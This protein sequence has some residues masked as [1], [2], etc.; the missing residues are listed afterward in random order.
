MDF[1]FTPTEEQ[2][3]DELREWLEMNLPNGWMEGQ[4]VLPD[5]EQEK[6]HFLRNWQKKL[7][8][9]GWAGINWPKEYG[10]RGATLMEQVIY[11]QE[12][13]RVQAPP[14]IN[15]MGINMVG[16][17]LIQMGTEWQKERYI[18]KILS[19]E[20]IWCQGY[21]EPNAGSDIAAIQTRAVK[22]GDQWVINGQK[23]WNTYAHYADR[24]FLLVRTD[25]TGRKHEGLT[26]FLVDMRQPGVEIRPIDQI[27]GR[28]EFNEIFFTDAVAYDEDIVG[29]V[30][31]GW[32]VAIALLMHERVGVAGMVFQV[33]NQFE[34]LV[35]LAKGTTKNGKSLMENPL[36]RQQLARYYART[37][38]SLLNYYRH[39]TNTIKQ[40]YPGPE[41]SIDKLTSSE[42]AKEMNEL[43]VSMI[44]PLGTLWKENK[45]TKHDWSERY[46]SSFGGTIAGGTSEILRN[47]IGE[48]ILKLPKDVKN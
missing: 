40:G 5:N 23:V 20:E 9:G 7:Y 31:Q 48:R 19:G 2:F 29:E 37:R 11:Q 16:P 25:R 38:G 24:C 1:S 12:V 3:R 45:G 22:Q 10:G 39:L 27:N 34:E 43:G 32:E 18:N 15:F 42:L 35:E 8:E 13:T 47:T 46:L 17:T 26:A 4:R 36:V 44:G 41:G 33:Q 6:E 14:V 28:S 30:H 21:S